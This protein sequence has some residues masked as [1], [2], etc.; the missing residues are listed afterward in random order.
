MGIKFKSQ[1]F[2]LFIFVHFV[3]FFEEEKLSFWLYETCNNFS[4][5]LQ[6]IAQIFLLTCFDE[7]NYKF[8]KR[9]I[10]IH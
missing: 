10:K 5:L 9:E 8:D 3:H 6:F 4:S 7:K 1:V 2:E